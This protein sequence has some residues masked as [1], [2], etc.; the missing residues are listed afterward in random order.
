MNQSYRGIRALTELARV[1]AEENVRCMRRQETFS[2]CWNE[3]GCLLSMPLGI[4]SVANEEVLKWMGSCLAS[5]LGLECSRSKFRILLGA[6]SWLAMC[7]AACF[8]K[9][10]EAVESAEGENGRKEVRSILAQEISLSLNWRGLPITLLSAGI[11]KPE[12]SL[13]TDTNK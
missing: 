10:E 11:C 8:D 4:R 13:R 9:D 7:W 12:P 2:S 1:S 6:T 5:P 3:L